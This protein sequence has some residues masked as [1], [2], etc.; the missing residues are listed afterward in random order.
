MVTDPKQF[1]ALCDLC[2]P[3]K[4]KLV[5]I[6]EYFTL[7]DIANE[8]TSDA[9]LAPY[10]RVINK[11]YRDSIATAADL[12]RAHTFYKD[13]SERNNVRHHLAAAI[14]DLI[15]ERINDKD[16][17]LQFTTD[18]LSALTNN[19]DDDN[20]SRL[21]NAFS[22]AIAAGDDRTVK[23]Y[24]DFSYLED[25]CGLKFDSA[26]RETFF[27][28]IVMD[29]A[30]YITTADELNRVLSKFNE[31]DTQLIIEKLQPYYTGIIKTYVDY[32]E[33][34]KHL[35][36]QQQ[37]IL[38]EIVKNELHENDA[39]RHF[40]RYEILRNYQMIHDPIHRTQYLQ[41]MLP[42]LFQ[43]IINISDYTLICKRISP[44]D[45]KYLFDYFKPKFI[46][47]DSGFCID[48][49][50]YAEFNMT[51]DAD[52]QKWFF[53]TIKSDL[54]SNKSVFKTRDLLPLVFSSLQPLQRTWLFDNIKSNI[55]AGEQFLRFSQ[56]DQFYKLLDDQQ[57]S[58]VMSNLLNLMHDHDEDLIS[59]I[60]KSFIS[61]IFSVLQGKDHT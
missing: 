29:P 12:I 23:T 46:R 59:S 48:P 42:I 30:K 5:D 16:S 37:V 25:M 2:I 28:H 13:S 47:G 44:E 15:I 58:F 49:I 24:Y 55:L 3:P 61:N 11:H 22:A 36:D 21:T 51:L 27:N 20:K 31:R 34:C 9:T 43:K 57:R 26:I 53:N 60:R 33:V 8:A 18:E 6:T 14:F 10:L 35:N 52:Q 4:M 39:F 19:L 54:I 40:D 38:Y 1:E 7:F 41:D 45:R 50:S 56:F 17:H 32:E